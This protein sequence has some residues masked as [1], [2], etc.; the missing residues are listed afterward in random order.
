MSELVGNPEEQFSGVASHNFLIQTCLYRK[1]LVYSGDK[2]MGAS[3]DDQ[4]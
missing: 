3:V 1:W 4:L 2:M